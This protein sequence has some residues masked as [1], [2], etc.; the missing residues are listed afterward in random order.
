MSF[1]FYDFETTG[2]DPRCDRPIQFAAIRTNE[3][4]EVID[5]PVT[6]YATLSPEILPH[7]QAVLV[8][9]LLPEDLE[10][11]GGTCEAVFAARIHA[12]MSRP[13]T[14]AVGFNSLRFDAELL[15]F[16][17]WRNLR[18]PYAHEWKNGNSRWDILDVARAVR[19]LRPEGIEW[20]VDEAGMPTLRLEALTA[21]NGIS[22]A[23]A[24]DALGDVEATIALARLLR[25]TAPKLFDYLL[26]LRS[27]HAVADLVDD[28]ARTAFVHVSGRIA[29]AQGS[30]SVFANLGQVKGVNTQRL[31]WDLRFDPTQVLDESV[32][33]LAER[34]FLS[35]ADVTETHTRLP[36]KLLH[37]NRVPVVVSASILKEEALVERMHLDRD[38]VRQHLSVM[39][40]H[41]PL[42]ADKLHTVLA[43]QAAYGAQDPECAL[44]DGFMPAADRTRLDVFNQQFDLALSQSGAPEQTA[45]VAAGLSD[46]LGHPWRDARLPELCFRFV[47][48]TRPDLLDDAETATW[49]N[50]IHARLMVE[51]DETP[52]APVNGMNYAQFFSTIE[53]LLVRTPS[54]SADDRVLLLRLKDWGRRHGRDMGLKGWVEP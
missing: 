15:R 26:T 40:Q 52:S 41:K 53:A 7:P 50:W 1:L 19:L 36:I 25:R 33:Q 35:Q 31:L 18:D 8:T 30:A 16:M 43:S 23:H 6:Y 17:F 29:S 49:Q 51:A 3:R 44:Y 24:H 12:V 46:L 22:H 37:L 39:V 20:P 42:I 21:A 4:L 34:R 10:P 48:R 27:K 45:G 28:P 5:E 54:I 2:A 13:D 14:C 38:A 47:A 32:E 9:G 11:A